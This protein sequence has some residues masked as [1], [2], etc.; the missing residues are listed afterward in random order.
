M[1]N[2][3]ETKVQQVTLGEFLKQ[4]R[5]DQKKT[6]VQASRYT[7]IKK[8]YLA[9]LE[10]GDYRFL[11]SLVFVKN[12]LKVYGR[13][14]QLPWPDL[15]KKL[16]SEF[17]IYANSATPPVKVT[18]HWNRPALFLPRFI[19][20]A[21]IVIVLAIFF[22]YMG[23][24]VNNFLQPPPLEISY[25]PDG[26]VS[27]EKVL[28]VRGQTLPEAQ[29]YINGQEIAVDQKGGFAEVVSLKDGFNDLQIL[30]KTRHSKE[31]IIY[32]QIIVE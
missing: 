5:E 9:A 29:V 8:E 26:L 16:K 14:L 13:F 4:V 32:R 15:E 25:P 2:F 11:P 18:A 7:K 20:L 28:E 22:T 21:V 23:W 1:T 3:Q 24:Q 31:R 27:A 10:E 12:Y 30:A 19:Y 17:P 6:L